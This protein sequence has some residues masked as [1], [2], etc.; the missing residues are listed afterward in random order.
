[1]MS[2]S[3]YAVSWLVVL[4]WIATAGAAGSPD[5][6]AVDEE[7]LKAAGVEVSDQ[8]VLDFLRRRIPAQ[9]DRDRV[10]TLIEQLGDDAFEVREKASAELTNLGL[11]A[12]PLLRQALKSSDVEVVRRAEECLRRA[13][14]RVTAAVPAAAARVLA[15]R[16]PPE[17]AQV[18]LAY[19]PF[20]EN[21]P[22]AEETRK[23]LTALAVR[24]AKPDP[25]LQAALTD[26]VPARRAAAAEALCRAGDLN[27]RPAIGKLLDDP[28]L[29][30][31]LAVARALV[32]AREKA[33]VPVLIDL[34]D[35]LPPERACQAEDLLLR[36]ADSQAPEDALTKD[37]AARHKC[38]KAWA[39]WWQQHQNDVK[40]DRLAKPR[41]LLGYTLLLLLDKG[42]VF[43]V[44]AKGQTRWEITNLEFP[45]D[46]ERLPGDRLLSAENHGNRV[47]ERDRR[48]RVIWEVRVEGPVMAQR[49]PNGNT[50]IATQIGTQ[51]N[52]I[53][54]RLIE[55][56]RA[57]K[58]VFSYDLPANDY[59][60]KVRKLANGD[61]AGVFMTARKSQYVRLDGTG[62]Q[63]Y[64][65]PVN[66]MYSGG[67]LDVL[68]NG[69]ALI[70][71][72]EP[73]RVVE[74]DETGRVVHEV[75]VPGPVAAVRL[76]NDN[77]LVTSMVKSREREGPFRAL[78]LDRNG[79]EVWHYDSDT[80]VTRA[81]RR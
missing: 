4:L 7:T 59:V 21:E 22:V 1:M 29:D 44:D 81:F 9:G 58:E 73:N 20:A 76:P 38:R 3:R 53:Q 62:K 45:L 28:D 50:F 51:F 72:Y 34:L 55:V 64:S 37:E 77:L 70:P 79:K 46:V 47:T 52:D 63:L 25:V 26:K 74:Y 39:D 11:L 16:K 57:G 32:E 54:S 33:A 42:R 75:A 78:E 68:P 5:R 43:E 41:P 17:A 49:L 31:R 69:H 35:R 23:A 66:V 67:R 36:L 13:K 12:E 30:V 15:R 8:A 60:M 19:L 80:R 56:N 2:R 48:G 6:A 71:E 61:I 40:L 10:K 24:D 27:Q 65:F 18:L 14:S